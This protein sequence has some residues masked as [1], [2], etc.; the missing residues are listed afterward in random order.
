MA[1]SSANLRSFR[2]TATVVAL[3]VESA[4]A[5]VAAVVDKEAEV[6]RRQRE[7]E[8]KKASNKGKGREQDLQT[9]FDDVQNRKKHLKEL[10]KE[11]FDAYV[12]DSLRLLIYALT[13]IT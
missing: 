7:G 4:L 1:M 8:K 5:E 2:H 10:M 6:L 13:S 11:I 12:F 3:E 9:K